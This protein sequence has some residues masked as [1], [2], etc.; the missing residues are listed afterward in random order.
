[1]TGTPERVQDFFFARS[2]I[3]EGSWSKMPDETGTCYRL[4]MRSKS[5]PGSSMLCDVWSKQKVV[6]N[7]LMMLLRLSS[8][9]MRNLQ[10]NVREF[11]SV[12]RVRLE[13]A[14]SRVCTPPL[15]SGKLGTGAFKLGRDNA[16]LCVVRPKASKL[17]TT[18]HGWDRQMTSNWSWF[19]ETFRK[20]V[21]HVASA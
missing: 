21:P 7:A 18:Q 9:F 17:D 10:N 11:P 15:S 19:S 16:Q 20:A 3:K 2:I 14:L 6:W 4:C 12:A 13:I 5:W 1:M 8:S